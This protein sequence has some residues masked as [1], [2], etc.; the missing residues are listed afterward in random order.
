MVEQKAEIA[1]EAQAHVQSESEK[2]KG[3]A[4]EYVQ[5]QLKIA[6]GDVM[7]RGVEIQRLQQKKW[8]LVS[9]LIKWVKSRPLF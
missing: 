4:F 6:E 5:Q 9:I 7:Q 2:L 8:R 3:E 1:Q